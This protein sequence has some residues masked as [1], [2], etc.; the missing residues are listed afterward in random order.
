[1][2][3]QS[4]GPPQSATFIWQIT[5]PEPGNHKNQFTPNMKTLKTKLTLKN[6]VSNSITVLFTRGLRMVRNAFSGSDSVFGKGG[7]LPD[8]L[9]DHAYPHSAHGPHPN[10]ASQLCDSNSLSGG[11]G[12]F[13]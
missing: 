6:I 4:F 3:R 1:L 8:Q 5:P 7:H 10:A 12:G 2:T 9:S 13:H 11:R